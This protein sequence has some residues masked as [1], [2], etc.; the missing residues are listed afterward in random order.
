MSDFARE[1]ATAV[2]Y[3]DAPETEAEFTSALARYQSLGHQIEDQVIATLP[4]GREVRLQLQ[5]YGRIVVYWGLPG[6]LAYDDDSGFCYDRLVDAVMA[7][8][9]WQRRGFEGEPEGWHRHY[10]TGRRR[11][12]GNPTRE[13][14]RQ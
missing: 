12:H 10:G 6:A 11:P 1:L 14:V 9:E 8:H 7:V 2:G 3:R 4:D 5:L 13:Y